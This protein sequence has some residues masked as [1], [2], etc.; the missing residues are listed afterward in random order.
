MS[1]FQPTPEQRCRELQRQDDWA[2]AN[3]KR[4]YHDEVCNL[5]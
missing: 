3:G 5:H 4:E 2:R 1:I